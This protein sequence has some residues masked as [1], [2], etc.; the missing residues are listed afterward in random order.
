MKQQILRQ[1]ATPDTQGQIHITV[2]EDFGPEVEVVV[3]PSG[4]RPTGIT[5]EN[6]AFPQPAETSGFVR[7]V[8]ASA[9][10]DCWNEL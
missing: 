9:E 7:D 5:P 6:P 8:I 2:P 10:E 3:L 4:S 1:T